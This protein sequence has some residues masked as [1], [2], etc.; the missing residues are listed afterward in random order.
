MR[1]FSFIC[2]FAGAFDAGHGV[3]LNGVLVAEVIE[4]R[5]DGREFPADR[6]RGELTSLELGSP[7]DYVSTRYQP[8]LVRPFDTAERDECLNIPLVRTPGVRIVDVGE[9]DHGGGDIGELL[10]FL[11]REQA[12]WLQVGLVLSWQERGGLVLAGLMLVRVSGDIIICLAH[13][14]VVVI[15]H[16]DPP[17]GA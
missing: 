7:G 9:P 4:Q 2:A 12:R 6:G 16:L 10:K 8:K 14:L 17:T 13:R 15:A 1:A 11:G 3:V 5:S